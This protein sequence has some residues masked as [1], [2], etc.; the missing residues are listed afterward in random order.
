MALERKTINSMI[1]KPTQIGTITETLNVVRMARENMIKIIVSHRGGE[2]EDDFLADMAVGTGAEQCKFGAPV[3]SERT[4][5]Y[6][7]LPGGAAEVQIL[8]CVQPRERR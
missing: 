4:A 7:Q 8:W 1:I 5:K 3:R 6:N 2:T